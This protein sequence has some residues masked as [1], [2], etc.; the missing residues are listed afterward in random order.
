MVNCVQ[1]VFLQEHLAHC[2]S[3]RWFLQ[4]SVPS[5]TLTSQWKRSKAPQGKMRCVPAGTFGRHQL[6]RAEPLGGRELMRGPLQPIMPISFFIPEKCSYRNIHR[7][8]IEKCSCRNTS[9]EGIKTPAKDRETPS[10]FHLWLWTIG[11]LPTP[12]CLHRGLHGEISK[13][14][15]AMFHLVIV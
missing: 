1:K 8:Y 14:M 15:V 4:V 13:N 11:F 3:S 5:R 10:Y 7:P 9:H 6:W 2:L 12:Y